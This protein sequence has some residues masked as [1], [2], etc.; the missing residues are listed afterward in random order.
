MIN[1]GSMTAA[2]TYGKYKGMEDQAAYNALQQEREQK[3]QMNEKLLTQSDN[4]LQEQNMKINQLQTEL[5]KQRVNS[6][7]L[8]VTDALSK[9]TEEYGKAQ[10]S[11]ANIE[12]EVVD[13]NNLPKD[14]IKS[15]Y[16]YDPETNTYSRK[17]KSYNI[18]E[19]LTSSVQEIKK[20]LVYDP[21][22]ADWINHFLDSKYGT[23]DNPIIDVHYSGESD[24]LVLTQKSGQ[25]IKMSP[26]MFGVATGIYDSM[27][28]SD[29]K[30]MEEQAKKS[31]LLYQ[32]NLQALKLGES[33]AL[34]N[35]RNAAA[36]LSSARTNTESF[37][38][39]KYMSDIKKN[40][41]SING[42]KPLTP[43]QEEK[44]MKLELNKE[45]NSLLA[46]AAKGEISQ[47]ELI[48]RVSANPELLNK[49]RN[50]NKQGFEKS[51]LAGVILNSQRD[52]LGLL[53]DIEK[54]TGNF[55]MDDKIRQSLYSYGINPDSFTSQGELLSAMKQEAQQLAARTL[56][57][58]TGAAFSERELD[59][60]MD[61]LLAITKGL[62]MSDAKAKLKGN[63]N[64]WT[65]NVETYMASFDP[66]A[67][68]ILR[69]LAD[70]AMIDAVD[71]RA[72]LDETYL[73]RREIE[74][75]RRLGTS[76]NSSYSRNSAN[77][78]TH[79]TQLKAL[80]NDPDKAR[81]YYNSLPPAVQNEIRA[82]WEAQKG[83][84]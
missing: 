41:A 73:H 5:M 10:G 9:F 35:Q 23:M 59:I 8:K 33:S 20:D 25:E 22:G 1:I 81:E 83:A 65:K 49:V 2:A 46:A 70:R 13:G 42:E 63:I 77:L 48:D 12:D 45:Y 11:M 74:K 57:L 40:E 21:E 31:E 82:K 15:Q 44:K 47:D 7:R 51:V 61:G 67:K 71:A 29:Q 69:G 53:D 78:D 39:A 52:V 16:N 56:N 36:G 43:N 27:K 4:E 72:H 54:L 18:P 84:R 62:S 37:K 55:T 79:L 66:G 19:G 38:Q 30:A 28:L 17:V 68:K 80:S 50:I 24:E 32:Q 60:Q 75:Q 64:A 58:L 34:I 26:L 3:R 14:F 76:T 6:T